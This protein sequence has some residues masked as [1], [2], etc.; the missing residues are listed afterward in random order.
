MGDTEVAVYMVSLQVLYLKGLMVQ[1]SVEVEAALT[2][3]G[4]LNLD[5]L[6]N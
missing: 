1:C 4:R 2:V 5:I 3:M 6:G